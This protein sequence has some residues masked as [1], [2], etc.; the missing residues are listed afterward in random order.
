MIAGD[1]QKTLAAVE[2]EVVTPMALCEFRGV[3]ENPQVDAGWRN[4][5]VVVDPAEDVLCPGEQKPVFDS[6]VQIQA[7]KGILG[8]QH[9][10]DPVDT[11]CSPH[12][13]D[14]VCVREF[15][16][17]VGPV[18]AGVVEVVRVHWSLVRLLVASAIHIT[19]AHRLRQPQIKHN[20]QTRAWYA[21]HLAPYN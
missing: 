6:V 18:H 17:G 12:Q 16:P 21:K 20:A 9:K 11:A 14:R 3:G 7:D 2:L 5:G 10:A 13:V 1:C 8:G 4:L 19:P 15:S